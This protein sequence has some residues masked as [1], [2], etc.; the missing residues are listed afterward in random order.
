VDLGPTPTLSRWVPRPAAAARPLAPP[1]RA[2]R[3]GRFAATVRSAPLERPRPLPSWTRPLAR[4][5]TGRDQ[6]PSMTTGPSTRRALRSAGVRAAA[7]GAVIHLPSLPEPTPASIGVVAHEL[8][9]VAD[10]TTRPRLFLDDLI[11]QGERRA[12]A[13]G[14]RAESLA[15]RAV[16]G[17][18][19]RARRR[20][21]QEVGSRLEQART[22]AEELAATG[23][24][25]VRSRAG[26]AAATAAEALPA[27]TGREPSM[28]RLAPDLGSL[29]VGG[30]VSA[31]REALGG[32]ASSGRD[33]WSGLTDRAGAMAR[34]TE[35]RAEGAMGGALEAARSEATRLA[36]PAAR[37]VDAAAESAPSAVDQARSGLAG[38]MDT[39]EQVT[40]Q[41]AS[42][43]ASASAATDPFSQMGEL[44]EALEERLLVELERR[45][46]RFAGMF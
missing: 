41:V 42:F 12:R 19:G 18:L 33:A 4:A 46:G 21:G 26:R 28:A 27:V 29:P 44:L 2:T 43:L 5:I 30:L 6:A 16:S 9:H 39:A 23:L 15:E 35:S 34:D 36:A 25:A 11:D 8:S 17:G 22:G 31:G 3:A 20:V 37:T 24:S 14:A 40:G 13:V 32:L 7:T 38:A 10:R 45:G 1:A